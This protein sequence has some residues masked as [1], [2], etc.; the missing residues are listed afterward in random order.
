MPMIRSGRCDECR[1]RKRKVCPNWL[2]MVNSGKLTVTSAMRQSPIVLDAWSGMFNAYIPMSNRG[3]CICTHLSLLRLFAAKKDCKQDRTNVAPVRLSSISGLP[4][5]HH[6]AKGCITLSY[7]ESPAR[8]SVAR[9]RAVSKLPNRS[10]HRSRATPHTCN[11]PSP[12]YCTDLLQ[13]DIAC[14]HG[15]RSSRRLFLESGRAFCWTEQSY[16]WYL[17]T[18]RASR[19]IQRRVVRVDISTVRR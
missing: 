19:Q 15:A 16:V 14:V 12:T 9:R 10:L 13:Q 6:L 3:S 5:S 11:V 2:K 18:K 4:K 1:R 17:A 7:H 8:R